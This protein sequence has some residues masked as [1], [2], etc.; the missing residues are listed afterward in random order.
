[1]T[2]SG[3]APSSLRD[4]PALFSP[5]LWAILVALVCAAIIAG[6][7]ALVAVWPSLGDA[8][9]FFYFGRRMNE[10]AR[11]YVD[12]WDLKPPIIFLVN[13]LADRLGE[14]L[15]ATAVI[16]T[17]TLLAGGF[18]V[19]MTLRRAGAWAPAIAAAL[20]FYALLLSFDAVAEGA[21]YT[22]I[23]VIPF[24]ALSIFLFVKGLRRERNAA[25]FAGAGAAAC[26]AAWSKLPGLAPLL[27]ELAFLAAM[28]LV[29]GKRLAAVRA[30]AWCVAG[31]AACAVLGAVLAAALTDLPSLID[32]SIL[33]PINYAK[34]PIPGTAAGL[35]ELSFIISALA[36]PIVL[37]ALSMMGGAAGLFTAARRS[38]EPGSGLLIRGLEIQQYCGLFALWA[39][40]DLAGALGTGRHYGHY[41]MP[42]A[43]SAGAAA[44][45]ALTWLRLNKRTWSK[46]A[47]GLLAISLLLLAFNAAR[48][49]RWRMLSASPG[50][51]AAVPEAQKPILAAIR[52]RAAPGDTLVTWNNMHALY[53]QSGLRNAVPHLALLNGIDSDYAARTKAPLLVEQLRRCPATFVVMSSDLPAFSDASRAFEREIRNLL[54]TSYRPVPL[55]QALGSELFERTGPQG[56]SCEAGA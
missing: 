3:L 28:L 16:E 5:R 52:A 36:V 43:A 48:T 1:M 40:A 23:Y 54:A 56:P 42:L 44:A 15:A 13:A 53:L 20:L 4:T 25:A 10:G 35:G 47:L 12:I 32:G 24:A 39:F 21:N 6:Y 9:L 14:Q 26:L 45:M 38:D 51:E 11:L 30:A 29:R 2:K 27:A 50:L 46:A 37:A 22:E 8:A 18:L 7:R 33:H 31:F 49:V 41:F 34:K 17:L 19:A 55:G